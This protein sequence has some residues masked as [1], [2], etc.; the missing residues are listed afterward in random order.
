MGSSLFVKKNF[1]KDQNFCPQIDGLISQSSEHHHNPLKRAKAIE[2]CIYAPLVYRN[3]ILYGI[4]QIANTN[5]REI[6]TEEDVNFIKL[7][8]TNIATCLHTQKQQFIEKIAAQKKVNSTILSAM[9]HTV[10]SSQ[11]ILVLSN[12]LFQE[13]QNPFK[14]L[15]LFL[16]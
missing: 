9:S 8:C 15:Q 4:V 14:A 6:F 1:S 16:Y 10:D 11:A 3:Q 2:N 13:K 12:K 5:P 7:V